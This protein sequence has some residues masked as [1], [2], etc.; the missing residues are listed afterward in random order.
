MPYRDEVEALSARVE[1]LERENDELATR[2]ERARAS[3]AS[4]AADL[5][6]LPAS[7]DVPWRSL[8]GGEPVRLT[9]VNTT[10][11]KLSLVWVSYDGAERVESTMIPEGRVTLETSTGYLFR[12][13]AGDEI[14]WQGYAR[15][16]QAELGPRADLAR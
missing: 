8:Y 16:G 6:G 14:V 1:I 7:A 15:V 3:L 5:A 11:R 10:K 4:V 12:M 2:L 13:R 9:F